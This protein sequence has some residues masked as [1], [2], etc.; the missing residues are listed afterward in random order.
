MSDY[1]QHVDKIASEDAAGL[2][3]AQESYGDS[4]MQRGGVGAF[5]MMCRKWDRIEMK[6]QQKPLDPNGDRY[7]I[8]EHAADDDRSEGLI[9]D[10]R[11][12][13]RYLMLVEAHLRA[14]GVS[15]A[16]SK[17]RDNAESP[18]ELPHPA[19]PELRHCGG[20]YEPGKY[21]FKSMNHEGPCGKD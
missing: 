7:D 20:E 8:F 14:T 1:I 18:E 12:M 3:K 21:C 6:C 19:P 4:W 10:I 17:H 15:C 5:M 9:D 2:H 16:Q 13:R 11:D